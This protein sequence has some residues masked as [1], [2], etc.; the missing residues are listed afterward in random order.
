MREYF[1]DFGCG[2]LSGVTSVIS[3]Y[4]LDTVKV[5]MQANSN[6]SMMGTITSIIR[7]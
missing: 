6:L 7:N 3:S 5:H 4:S 1:E 2:I